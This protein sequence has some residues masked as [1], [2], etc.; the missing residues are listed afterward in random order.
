MKILAIT[1]ARGGSKGVPK[2][3]IKL[4]DGLPLISYTIEAALKSTLIDRYIISTDDIEIKKIAEK[5]GAEVPFLRP[6]YLAQ[7]SS[8]SVS[9][10]KHAVDWAEKDNEIKYDY[11]VELMCTNPFKTHEDIDACI[12]KILISNADSVI[13]VHKLDDH[14][15]ARIKKII[16]DRI[17]DFCIQETPESRR[18]DL[19]PEAYIR[20]GAIYV[21]KRD[22]LM[23]ENRRY[24]SF[25]SRP[26]ILSPNKVINIDT[27]LDF[28]V[29]ESIIKKIKKIIA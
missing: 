28:I 29:A 16:N 3:N 23:V 2:K 26:Y 9:A 15:P 5:Y 20:S 24:G 25:E 4:L 21:I 18:Q 14:H 1:L 6:A 27:E 17:E 7:D 13:A 10:L 8:S 12:R 11:I 22:H 19:K